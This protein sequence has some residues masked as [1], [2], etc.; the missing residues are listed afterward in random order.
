MAAEAGLMGCSGE[1]MTKLV[2]EINKNHCLINA[3]FKNVASGLDPD[4]FLL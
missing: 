3:V 1:K 2:G 4:S